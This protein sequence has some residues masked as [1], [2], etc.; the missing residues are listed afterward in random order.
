MLS[1]FSVVVVGKTGSGKS[2]M[3]NIL[4]QNEV[5]KVSGNK[6]STTSKCDYRISKNAWG[7]CIQVV[8]T[9]G[10]YDT[11]QDPGKALQELTNVLSLSSPGP[12]AILFLTRRDQKFT[13]EEYESFMQIRAMFGDKKNRFLVLVFSR[14]EPLAGKT[15]EDD[16][17]GAPENLKKVIKLVGNK[18]AVI[19]NTHDELERKQE[20]ENILM[21]VDQASKNGT[22]YYRNDDLKKMMK[23]INDEIEKVKEEKNIEWYEAEL[24]VKR[25]MVLETKARFRLLKIELLA[26]TLFTRV[27]ATAVGED[28]RQKLIKSIEKEADSRAS[29]V[30][31]AQLGKYLKKKEKEHFCF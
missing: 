19:S 11:S 17:K 6:S 28:K 10:L 21:K 15:I 30:T 29:D 9:P 24:E 12:H 25:E 1:V 8:D 3:G 18:Y 22:R 31:L 2:T 16:L 7:R 14:G 4:L 20:V 13:K 26:V 5:F 23:L 27:F